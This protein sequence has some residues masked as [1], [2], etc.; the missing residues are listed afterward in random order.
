M[1]AAVAVILST[2]RK[3]ASGKDVNG[4]SAENERRIEECG[5][6]VFKGKA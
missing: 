3:F 2:C 4:F 6:L 1:I 5:R